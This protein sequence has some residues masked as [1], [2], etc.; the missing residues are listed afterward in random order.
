MAVLHRPVLY[1]HRALAFYLAVAGIISA[2]TVSPDGTLKISDNVRLVVLD[3]SVRNSHGQFVTDLSQSDFSLFEDGKSR[4]VRHFANADQPITVGLVVDNSGSMARKRSE[5]IAAGLAFARASNAHDQFFVVNFNNSVTRGLPPDV[6]F[7]DNLL[8]LRQALYFGAAGGQ[9]ALYD[10]VVYSLRHLER[11]R[12]EWR[13]LVVVSDGRDNCSS[14]T[15]RQLIAAIGS[16]RATI[17]TVGLFDREANDLNPKVLHKI[18]DVSG[19]EFFE[20]KRLSDVAPVL[21]KISQD[22]RHR[23]VLEFVPDQL[24]ER[25]TV[26]TIKV[27]AKQ[28]GMKLRVRTRTRYQL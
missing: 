24:H 16:S 26:R 25:R 12:Y 6:P 9:T 15:L 7:T 17:Y 14:H 21:D 22:I 11:A 23:Y 3:V 20:P 1:H 4:K 18:A 5:V 13:T 27:V 2:Q 28:D 19:G 8:L 10:A